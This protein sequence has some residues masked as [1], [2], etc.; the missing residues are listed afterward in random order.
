MATTKKSTSEK[1][2]LAKPVWLKYT[3]KEVKEIILNIIKKQPEITSEKI[4]LILRDTFGIPKTK[5]YGF[6]IGS[7]EEKS[8]KKIEVFN[9]KK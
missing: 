8:C 1:P 6:K 4:G 7:F 2:K 5:I 3:E 9:L